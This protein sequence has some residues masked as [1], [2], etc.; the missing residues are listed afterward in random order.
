VLIR[1]LSTDTQ[2]GLYAAATQ[3][4]EF[5]SFLPLAAQAMMLPKRGILD[6]GRALIA[7]PD[8]GES[9]LSF[10]SNMGSFRPNSGARPAST[11]TAEVDADVV[12]RE[13]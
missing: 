10:F 13:T 9:A 5:V 8:R 12:P 1:N 4:S 6:R 3:W 2:T 11:A 7:F